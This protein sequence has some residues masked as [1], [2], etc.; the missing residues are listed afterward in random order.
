[1]THLRAPIGCVTAI[2]S[3]AAC[4]PRAD[5]DYRG[6]S[7]LHLE[8][9]VVLADES[10][11]HGLVPAVAFAIPDGLEIVDVAV[12]GQFPADFRM[13]LYAP[14]PP[15]AITSELRGETPA[16][17]AEFAI[18]AITAV[19]PDH[20][21]QLLFASSE[22]SWSLDPRLPL[23]F[24]DLSSCAEDPRCVRAGQ[25][26]EQEPRCD[27]VER[28]CLDVSDTEC[29]TVGMPACED[30]E[31][32]ADCEPLFSEGNEL[33]HTYDQGLRKFAGFSERYVIIWTRSG[34][35]KTHLYLAVIGVEED[36]APGYHLIQLGE[37]PEYE[38]D[39]DSDSDSSEDS[40]DSSDQD[41]TDVCAEE[42]AAETP[43]RSASC[44]AFGCI[45]RFEA[46]TFA[47][48]NERHGTSFRCMA[49]IDAMEFEEASRI[50]DE[51][52]YIAQTIALARGVSIAELVGT[53]VIHDPKT[54]LSIHISRDAEPPIIF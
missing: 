54:K 47:R 3:L 38:D 1:M 20:S 14:P 27:R 9:R 2:V 24:A 52:V 23:G 43:S 10:A 33:I 29:R 21:S 37:E 17:R 25:K 8:G 35:P 44:V 31:D 41:S 34:L 7:L 11:P 49:E 19:P 40:V 46:E 32:E 26:C 16:E 15:N 48:Y 22:A 5:Q 39:S 53:K 42:R 4:D 30:E 18:G 6:E 36:L 51:L 50:E 28:W 12:Q 13:D 45:E